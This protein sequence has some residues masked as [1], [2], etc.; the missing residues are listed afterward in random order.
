M[1]S[2][3]YYNSVK[4]LLHCN[5][6]N[7]ST[8][9]TDSSSAP[10]TMTVGGNAQLS[11]AQKQYGTAS[12]AFDGSGDYVQTDSSSDFTFGTGDFTIEGWVRFST[13]TAL[14]F[15]FD[16]RPSTGNYPALWFDYGTNNALVYFVNGDRRII[17]TTAPTA[18][19]WRHWA[20]SR[21]GTTTKL[22]YNGTEE[23]QWTDTTNYVGSVMRFGYPYDGT[24]NYGLNGYLD[25][26]RVTKGVARYTG[27]FT[28]PTSEFPNTQYAFAGSI[29]ESLAFTKWRVS[30]HSAVD[31]TK[32]GTLSTTSLTYDLP[33]STADPFLITVHPYVDRIWTAGMTAVLGELVTPTSTET[34]P[35]LFECTTGG[36]VGGSEPTWNATP[37]ATTNDG[38]AV[39]TCVAKLVNP[40]SIGPKIPS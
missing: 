3:P 20:I 21:S 34:T 28:P 4:L 1:A 32:A 26:V 9:I 11:T 40:I 25:D 12:L 6:T 24:A 5:G 38:S 8:T 13:V 14:Q 39:W 17:G 15:I 23:G 29:I 19:V 18:N 33:V 10:H 35:Y 22:F 27:A 37:G 2:D 7:A 31:G 16:M 36:A 30:A